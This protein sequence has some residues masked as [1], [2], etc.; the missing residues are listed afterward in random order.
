MANQ[1]NTKQTVLEDTIQRCGYGE[2][3]NAKI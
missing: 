1:E 2:Q 3:Q